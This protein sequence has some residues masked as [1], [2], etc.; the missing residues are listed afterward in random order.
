SKIKQALEKEPR[1]IGAYVV[2]SVVQGQETAES[3]FDLAVVVDNKKML[4]ENKVY[5]LTKDINFPKDLDLSV[6]DQS[7]SPL[8]LF[9]I[10]SKGQRIYEKNSA[11]VVAFEAFTLHNYYDTQHL[12]NIYYESL[13]PK[14][15]YANQ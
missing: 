9:Q 5:N 2:G 11:D 15:S 4:D 3:D 1:V 7:S 10:I 8:F 6:V 14:F 12:R 13:K